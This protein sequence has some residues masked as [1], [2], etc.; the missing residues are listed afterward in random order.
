[1][2]ADAIIVVVPVLAV[3]LRWGAGTFFRGQNGPRGTMGAWVA[4]G[5]RPTVLVARAGHVPDLQ[6]KRS[7][8]CSSGQESSP[9]WI[10]TVE[11]GG[12]GM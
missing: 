10:G 5:S 7:S 11:V 6:T 1:M 12:K 3:C 9:T 4:F 2:S 8:R